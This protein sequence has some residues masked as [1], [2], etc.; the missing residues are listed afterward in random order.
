M[1]RPVRQL[2]WFVPDAAAAA[3]R[4]VRLYGS[5]P[6]FLA[7][8]IG[9][10]TCLH[11]GR[12]AQLDHTSAYGQWGE[13]MVEF[14]QQNL[15]GPSVFTDLHPDGGSGLH[16]VALIVDDLHVELARFAREGLETAL[17]AE[18]EQGGVAF[19]MIDAVAAEGVFIELYGP[20]PPILALYDGVRRAHA[21]HENAKAVRPLAELARF[22]ED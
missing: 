20:S 15:P 19:A 14:V 2:A 12:P 1:Q 13:M 21:R 11:R 16:H 9:L 7:E 4:H 3:E 10:K 18:T 6:F 17:Y 22:Q 8:H 5:G